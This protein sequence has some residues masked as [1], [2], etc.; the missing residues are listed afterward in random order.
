M[1]NP[2]L[3]LDDEL[4]AHLPTPVEA[5]TALG[6]PQLWLKNDGFTG[7]R[8]GGN[9]L[10]KLAPILRH[11]AAKGLR[12]I[13]TLGAAG[14]HHVL[15]TTL[16]GR[17]QGFEVIALL[18]P[19]WHTPHAERVFRCSVGLGAQILPLLSLSQLPNVTRQLLGPKTL[20]LGPGGMGNLGSSGYLD[21]ATELVQQ[22]Q[23]GDLPEP[24]RIVVAVGSG[25]TAAGL[26]VGLEHAGFGSRLIGVG[27]TGNPANRPSVLLQAMSL[28]RARG[29]STNWRALS[30]RLEMR[31]DALGA[32]Y[33]IAS[34]A[35]A[36]ATSVA[37]G[38]GLE[39][40]PTYTAKTF[41]VALECAAERSAPTLYWHTLSAVPLTPL[42]LDA[43]ALC[44]LPGGLRSLLRTSRR[45]DP[46]KEAEAR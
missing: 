35:G 3:A 30:A 21:A 12:R 32:G 45:G 29:V 26:L 11:A 9:K 41:A 5:L 36:L 14:S 28:A 40:D 19:Q 16:Y 8:Y 31:D 6:F 25:S 34:E 10:R 43:P 38:C 27:V 7:E 44:D 15:A 22:V 13:V 18:T 33:G 2:T 24:E 37:A 46:P 17:T 42:L 4:S 23:R 20:W 1:P 39:L